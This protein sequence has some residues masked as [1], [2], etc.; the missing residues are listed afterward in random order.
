M[1]NCAT[2]LAMTVMAGMVA[3]LSGQD[4]SSSSVKLCLK[5]FYNLKVYRSYLVLDDVLPSWNKSEVEQLCVSYGQYSVC[6]K[7]VIS[8]C[9]LSNQLAHAGLN[10]AFKYLCTNS[11]INEYLKYHECFGNVVLRRSVQFCNETFQK[12]TS[13]LSSW[14][15][16]SEKRRQY[17]E[18][19][20]HY[21]DCVE[22]AVRPVCGDTASDWQNKYVAKLHQPALDY[23]GCSGGVGGRGWSAVTIIVTAFIALTIV[24]MVVVIAVFL[25]VVRRRHRLGPRASRRHRRRASSPPDYDAPYVVYSAEGPDGERQLQVI[26]LD[27]AH[28]PAL[29]DASTVPALKGAF[30][31]PPPYAE[32]TPSPGSSAADRTPTTAESARENHGIEE[33][34]ASR[35]ATDP[36]TGRTAADATDLQP[37]GNGE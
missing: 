26:G 9:P 5:A 4:C 13:I 7:T 16:D 1:S 25:V 3:P 30:V 20:E 17:C 15:S 12:K 6:M 19:Y 24:L 33:D 23:I 21:V 2:L 11:T 32:E 8:H 27:G 37:S 36:D 28:S 14:T 10:D 35:S 18:Y 22:A 29:V 34:S 31:P